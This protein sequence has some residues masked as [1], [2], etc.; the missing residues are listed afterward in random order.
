[1]ALQRIKIKE[2]ITPRLMDEQELRA[3]T[4]LGRNKARELGTNAQSVV[5][6]GARVL[7]DRHKVD[8]FLD[9]QSATSNKD[10][11]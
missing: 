11:W 4:N 8:K 1:M 6:I 9:E 7:Y 2:D 5:R 10:R 3:Y